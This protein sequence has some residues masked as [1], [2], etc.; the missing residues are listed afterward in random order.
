MLHE[1]RLTEDTLQQMIQQSI[2]DKDDVATMLYMKELGKRM[3]ENSKFSGAIAQHQNALSMAI[4]LK[5]TFEIAQIYNNLGTN[6][7][8]IGGLA[9]AL[10]YHYSALHIAE[11]YSRAD[12]DDGR[13]NVV[14]ALNG[15][16]NISKALG[17]LD[18]GEKY[19]RRA[20][21]IETSLNSHL[22][23]AINYA[24]LG[25]VFVE[26]QQYDSA[27]YFYEQ[28]MKHNQQIHSALGIGL[29]HVH[30]GE[31]YEIKKQY[32]NAKNE[33]RKAYDIMSS[34]SDTWHA[35]DARIGLAR[36]SILTGDFA[37]AEILIK[38]IERDAKKINSKRHLVDTYYLK[39]SLNE[40][41]GHFSEALE[42]YKQSVAMRDSMINQ[43]KANRYMDTRLSYERDKNLQRI[44]QI[45]RQNERDQQKKQRYLY[46]SWAV[47][48]VS[49]ILFGSLFY[50][51]KQRSR[52]NKAL[53]ELAKNR[54]DF[55]TNITHEFRTPLTVIVGLTELMQKKDHISKENTT[56]TLAAIQRQG[57]NLLHLVNQLL[58]I[59]KLSSGVDKP[60]WKHG[61]I[62]A[63]LQMVCE[64]FRL[65]C[66][67]KK[68]QFLFY[69][70]DTEINIDFVPFYIDKVMSNLLSNAIKHSIAGDKV[71]VIVKKNPTSVT[72]RV[73][74]TGDG[75]SPEDKEHIFE[76][77]YQGASHQLRQGSGIG[78][79]LVKQFVEAMNGTIAVESK[80]GEGSMFTVTLPLKNAAESNIMPWNKWMERS[81]ENAQRQTHF[82]RHHDDPT[83]KEND[84]EVF[85]EA[86]DRPTILLV[87]DNRDIMMY[88]RTFLENKYHIVEARNGD[89]GLKKAFNW[90]PDLVVTDIMMPIKDG[91]QM[92]VE[93]K[94]SELLNHIPIIMLTAKVTE[95]DR[96]QGLKCG[97]EAYI[98]KPFRSEELLVCI[99]KILHNRQILKE[100]YMNSVI[101]DETI[102]VNKERDAMFVHKVV[103]LI[104]AKM[105]EPGLTSAYIAENMSVSVSQL[106]RKLKALTGFSSNAYVLQ[107]RILHAKKL[108]A[109]PNISITEV[110]E[111][112]GFYD[113]SYFSRTFK[114]YVGET[115]TDYQR[116]PKSNRG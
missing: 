82:L 45:N 5:D 46:I 13:K 87:E 14:M 22:G 102:P 31:I 24:N 83:M 48:V 1:R 18:D 25:D 68:I 57:D 51:Y 8:R 49:I 47:I 4:H 7:R 77:F 112:T 66:E 44:A 12:T 75:I 98:E 9:E 42:D 3:R 99:E 110:A 104:Y 39:H 73:A 79:S 60:E 84:E 105:S 43:Q 33:F 29:C 52:T 38:K 96:I 40:K 111:E 61:N 59:S 58:D 92:C 114:R 115:P 107:V 94:E 30:F 85:I 63:Y 62:V 6:F 41:R 35:L 2:A 70:E 103:D 100:K 69:C 23:Q 93:L 11:E 15:L 80:L 78:L 109:N 50:A 81:C 74:D 17:Y 37:E 21:A 36:A 32:E 16:G 71:T 10:D 54:S 88:V 53:K 27:W 106:N 72:L 56:A 101:Q 28:S 26:K 108:L 76:L 19:F 64:T 113:V 65:Y 34:F 116:K 89:D 97:V 67:D 91:Y 95:E 90:V 55:F 20:L 86:D